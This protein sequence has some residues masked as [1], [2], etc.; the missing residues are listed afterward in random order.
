MKIVVSAL[1][2]GFASMVHAKRASVSAPGFTGIA[3]VTCDGINSNDLDDLSMTVIAQALEETYDE[4]QDY[5]KNGTYVKVDWVCTNCGLDDRYRRKRRPGFTS[6]SEQEGSS[7]EFTVDWI[8]A[9]K[10]PGDDF[11]ATS[12]LEATPVAMDIGS[13]T[14]GDNNNAIQMWEKRLIHALIDTRRTDFR[15]AES[16]AIKIIPGVVMGTK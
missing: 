14:T 16:C 12:F 3:K 11:L 10:C 5:Q 2:I 1:F 8:C 15:A 13:T 6:K 9:D 4:L 7:L